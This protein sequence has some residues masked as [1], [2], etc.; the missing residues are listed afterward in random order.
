MMRVD[1]ARRTGENSLI[2]SG[3]EGIVSKVPAGAGKQPCTR[4][5]GVAHNAQQYQRR[6]YRDIGRLPQIMVS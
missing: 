4:R 3:D 1:L 2:T 5:R 6:K